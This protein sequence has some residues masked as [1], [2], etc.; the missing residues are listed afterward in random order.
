MKQPVKYCLQIIVLLTFF[1]VYG[2]LPSNRVK[3][4]VIY[5]AGSTVRSPRLGLTTQIPKGWAGVLPG[6]A[7]VFLLV[8]QGMD[9]GE[10][11]VVLNQNTDL[12]GQRKRWESGMQ[13]DGVKLQPDGQIGMRGSD[14][15]TT[16]AKLNGQAA[17]TQSKIYLEAKCSPAGF[18]LS[19]VSTADPSSFE[20]VKKALQ[21]LVDHTSFGQVTNESPFANFDWKKFF[22][23]KVLLV[24]GFENNSKRENEVDLCADGTFTSRMTRT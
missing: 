22:S 7:E 13:L 5:E 3:P 19:F 12:S 1:N 14:I 18:C 20:N 16:N 21:E 15:L 6:D 4:G 10:I 23:G 9:I 11:Y 8:P 17:N 24:M 2:Q